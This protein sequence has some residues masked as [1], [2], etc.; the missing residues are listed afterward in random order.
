LQKMV[1]NVLYIYNHA[2]LR[3]LKIHF[4]STCTNLTGIHY[5]LT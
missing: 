1:I 2:P 5:F 4:S 3:L